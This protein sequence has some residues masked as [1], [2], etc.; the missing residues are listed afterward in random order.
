M[1]LL[2]IDDKERIVRNVN[3]HLAPNNAVLA[4]FFFINKKGVVHLGFKDVQED[5]YHEKPVYFS[6]ES[7]CFEVNLNV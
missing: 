7:K 6:V 5:N 1:S 4:W 3:K 2:T